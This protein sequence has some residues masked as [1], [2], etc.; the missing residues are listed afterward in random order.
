MYYKITM[1]YCTSY[2][3][4]KEAKCIYTNQYKKLMTM[5]IFLMYSYFLNNLYNDDL[6]QII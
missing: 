6:L 3:Q 5:I 2:S 1:Y 4:N